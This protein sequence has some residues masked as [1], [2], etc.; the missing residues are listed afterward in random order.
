MAA[1]LLRLDGIDAEVASL[2]LRRGEPAARGRMRTET[3]ASSGGGAWLR[4]Q[5]GWRRRWCLVVD[6]AR[7]EAACRG[8]A[9][10]IRQPTT[11][12]DSGR[13]RRFADGTGRGRERD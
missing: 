13:R 7:M 3:A 12:W 2:L 5:R 9:A 4:I 10:G 11:A 1:V 6:L 8:A